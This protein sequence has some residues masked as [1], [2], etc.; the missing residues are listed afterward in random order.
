[1][2]P[3][4][5]KIDVS[6]RALLSQFKKYF[7]FRRNQIKAN[8]KLTKEE[9]SIALKN[10]HLPYSID[11]GFCSG[12]T[13]LWLY[14]KS[15][16]KEDIFIKLITNALYWREA[17]TPDDV[18]KSRDIDDLFEELFQAIAFLQTKHILLHNSD[19]NKK[20]PENIAYSF[21]FLLPDSKSADPMS[22]VEQ[23]FNLSFVYTKESLAQMIEDLVKNNKMIYLNNVYHAIGLVLTDGKYYLYD[24]N[25]KSKP[26]VFNNSHDVANAIFTQYKP[27]NNSKDKLTLY[28]SFLNS[29]NTKLAIYPSKHEYCAEL[30][31]KYKYDSNIINDDSLIHL[32]VKNNEIKTFQLLL[33]HGLLVN[34]PSNFNETYAGLAISNNKKEYEMLYLLLCNNTDIQSEH[35]DLSLFS[36]ASMYNNYHA[37]T[38]LLAFGYEPNTHE[39]TNLKAISEELFNAVINT[40]INLQKEF[41]DPPKIMNIKDPH[42][43]IMY[44]RQK[45]LEQHKLEKNID[46]ELQDE[47]GQVFQ[48][49]NAINKLLE[50]YH[51][52]LHGNMYDATYKGE[53][54]KLLKH[55]SKNSAD[56]HGSSELISLFTEIANSITA[57]KITDHSQND[58]I[59][60]SIIIQQLNE[61]IAKPLNFN[62][63]KYFICYEAKNIKHKI[64]R[65]LKKNGIESLENHIHKEQLNKWQRNYIFFTPSQKNQTSEVKSLDNSINKVQKILNDLRFIY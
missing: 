31:N 13:S 65:Y 10:C 29:S 41:L 62:P 16:D 44:L 46:I 52:M 58:L 51:C 33:N 25:H 50:E 24:P 2:L 14:Y 57:K 9:K 32:L 45:K 5:P 8:K 56:F 27:Y 39:L 60:I 17:D 1:M 28:T 18:M 49:E 20:S 34:K 30:I 15:L 36:I 6:Q 48:N 61:L 22:A 47:K 43:I 35:L 7:A 55:F 4:W 42:G 38:L 63:H 12:I 11:E 40:A 64:D 23:E 54:Y 3:Q 59:E 26:M 37:L 21:E 53:L 19:K